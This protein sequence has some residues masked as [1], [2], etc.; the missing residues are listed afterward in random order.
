MDE[1]ILFVYISQIVK[2]SSFEGCIEGN[3]PY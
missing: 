3:G 2:P 1:N